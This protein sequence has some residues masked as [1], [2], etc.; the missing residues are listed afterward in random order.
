MSWPASP[1]WLDEW[2]RG[3]G[4][5]L[6]SPLSRASGS[7]QAETDTYDPELVQAIRGTPELPALERLA[8]YHRQYWFRLLTVL[9][10]KYPL[11]ARLLGF[12]R[13]NQRASA[14]LV[15]NPPRS[16]DIDVVG[17][18]F[19][20]YL[21]GAEPPEHLPQQALLEA[22]RIDA[23]YQR[24]VRAPSVV[25]FRLELRDAERLGAGRLRRSEAVAQVREH[26]PLCALRRDALAL[27]G[28]TPLGLPPAHP[29]ERHWLVVR[30]V[31]EVATTP[32]APREAELLELLSQHP[33]SDALALLEERC[34]DA[35][36]RELPSQ[37][38][39]WLSRSVQL[40]AWAAL[41]S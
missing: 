16:W 21:A 4:E 39:A 3:V 14:F 40:G 17:D 25:P 18:G 22:A 7:L 19:D 13:F 30:Q 26:W 11:T 28:D 6:R 2:Q 38:E 20:V 31:L 5:L 35:E 36:R 33:V 15:E 8:V 24:V 27:A 34:T 41:D 1:A 23:A 9:Q 10:G 29:E 12:W 37:V 32:L